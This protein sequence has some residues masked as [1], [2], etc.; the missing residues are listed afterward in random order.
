MIDTPQGRFLQN[1][2]K[3]QLLAAV[4]WNHREYFVLQ[5]R[6]A[7]GA[8][9]EADGVTWTYT[10][11]REG[12]M[13]LFP[14]LTEERAGEQLD[15]IVAFYCEHPTDALIGCWS[16]N[17]PQT[18]DLEA[19]LLARGFQPGWQ[20]NWMWLDLEQIRTEHPRPAGLR[21]ETLQNEPVWDV[22]DLPYFSREMA[23]SR[24]A[25]GYITPE[26]ITHFAAFLDGKPVGHS[27]LFL[28][29]GP[30]GVAGLYSVGVVP[31]AR[32]QGIGKA[33]TQAA[34][35]HARALGCR[36]AL[37][38][39][40]GERMYNQIGFTNIGYGCTWW[41][42]VSRR[43]ASRLTPE[44]IALAEAVGR[45]AIRALDRL[46]PSVEALE[47]PLPCGMSLLQLAAHTR[48][49]AAAEWLV[50]RGAALDVLTAW[51]L[52]W[53]ER[54]EELLKEN[55]E[56]VN[57]RRGELQTTLLHEA[58]ERN[59]LALVRLALAFHPDLSIGDS[60]FHSTALGW[61]KH[62]QRAEMI[63]LLEAYAAS[64]QARP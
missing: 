19:R 5:A 6:A 22:D 43:I 49:P 18:P 41:L 52:G 64:G 23:A 13:I 3:E 47:A 12:G 25:D 62:F 8:V 4:A 1:A 21:I 11:P 39:G 57:R 32:N 50:A 14:R 58:V 9:Q 44:R 42:N 45:G 51:D 30:L 7:Q 17:P 36:H 40:T 61:A 46:S 20:P 38:N 15:A 59:D 2:A 63:S 35:L 48:Q 10:G 33:V 37:L 56:L 28:T 53:R 34:C 60:R 54:A 29:N 24:Q 27:T 55:P 16:L 26:Q 31:A